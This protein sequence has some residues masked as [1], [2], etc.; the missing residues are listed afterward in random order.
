MSKKRFSVSAKMRVF[1]EIIVISVSILIAAFSF[2]VSSN[3][4]D[5]YFKRMAMNSAEN[6]STMIDHEYLLRLKETLESKEYQD[7]RDKA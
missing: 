6:F 4:M 1:V 7:M 2:I 3:Q 5:N